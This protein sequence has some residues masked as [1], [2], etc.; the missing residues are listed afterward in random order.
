MYR[1]WTAKNP[2]K[3]RGWRFLLLPVVDDHVIPPSEATDVGQPAQTMPLLG[4]CQAR[5]WGNGHQWHLVTRG[6]YIRPHS[7]GEAVLVPGRMEFSKRNAPE[8]RSTATTRC[9]FP[10]NWPQQAGR[11]CSRVKVPEETSAYNMLWNEERSVMNLL[12]TIDVDAIT[13]TLKIRN[14]NTGP[15]RNDRSPLIIP[16]IWWLDLTAPIPIIVAIPSWSERI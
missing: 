6:S 10:G 1:C 7:A 4:Q 9:V 12:P 11:R 14:G 15:Y 13:W 16:F 2:L 8:R 3:T 5:T